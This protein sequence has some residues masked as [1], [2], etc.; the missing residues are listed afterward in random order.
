MNLK[1]NLQIITAC[2]KA[3]LCKRCMCMLRHIRPSVR[4]APVLCQNEGSQRDAVFTIGWPSVSGFLMP[5]IVD[6]DDPFQVKFECKEIDLYSQAVHVSP[7]NSGT[8][9]DS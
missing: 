9:M 1:T 4:H 6:G 8:V 2:R 5:R 3:I 7:H